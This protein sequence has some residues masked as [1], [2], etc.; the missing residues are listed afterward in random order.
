[1]KSNTWENSTHAVWLHAVSSSFFDAIFLEATFS[2][3]EANGVN[4]FD[5]KN[6]VDMEAYQNLKQYLLQRKNEYPIRWRPPSDD[7]CAYY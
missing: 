5:L 2:S 1:M 4:A 3:Y 6:V 7:F